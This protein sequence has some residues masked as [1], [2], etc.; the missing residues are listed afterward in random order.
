MVNVLSGLK[1]EAVFKFFEELT[2]IP[3]GSGN[4]KQVS[5]YLVKFAKDNGLEVIQEECLNVIIKKPGT[6]GYENAPTVILQGHMDIVCAK[7]EDLDFD[8]S[9]DPIPLMVDGDMIRTKGTTLGADNGI[10]VAMIMAILE[11]KD[12]PHP[13]LVALIT[14]AEETGMDGVLNLNPENVSGDILINIDS[15]EEGTILASC[16]GGVNNIIHLP[17]EWNEADTN[18]IGYKISIKGLIGGHSGIEIN[19]NRANAIKL[20]GRLLESLDKEINIDI[21]NVSGGEK[22]NAIAKMSEAVVMINKDDEEKFKRIIDEHQKIFS[23]EYITSD[24]NINISLEKVDGI[25]KVFSLNT[26][27]GLISILRLIPN[28]VQTMSAD[29][30]GLVESSNNIGV[31]TTSEEE[32]KFDSAVRSSVKSLKKEINDR[33]QN[34]CDLVG[35]KMELV[36]DYPEWEFKVESP[37]RD[38]MAEVYRDMFGKEVKVDAIHAGLECGF[39]KEKIGDIDMVSIGPNIYDVHTPNEHI[40]ISSTK[41]VFEFLCEVLKRL[42]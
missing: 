8:F 35:A 7:N 13:P 37:I 4:E 3:R 31:L 20:L 26:K 29:I 40:S 27:K 16:A 39:L 10:A 30:E 1:P 34:I 9:K 19:K 23:N 32:I 18:K 41:R 36:A 14:V 42:K 21:A 2:R 15:E 28:G 12:L 17:I 22:M 38:L 5:D 11:S 25:Q 24:P 6:E 33:I